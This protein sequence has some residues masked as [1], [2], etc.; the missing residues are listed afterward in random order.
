MV[1]KLF[2]RRCVIMEIINA[3]MITPD[4]HANCPDNG[5]CITNCPVDCIHC[6]IYESSNNIEDLCVLNI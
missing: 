6:V 4:Y 3:G 1:V 2:K 5:G